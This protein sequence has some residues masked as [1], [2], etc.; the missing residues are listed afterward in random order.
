MFKTKKTTKITKKVFRN[1]KWKFGLMITDLRFQQILKW[2]FICIKNKKYYFYYFFRCLLPGFISCF[3]DSFHYYL[4]NC[5]LFPLFEILR[6]ASKGFCVL[7]RKT[8]RIQSKANLFT[9]TT[10][11]VFSFWDA[12]SFYYFSSH[13]KLLV[14]SVKN[15]C[16]ENHQK[17]E[18]TGKQKA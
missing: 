7:I 1:K 18:E 6:V 2:L 10:F 15:L 11:V 4:F 17:D 9:L 8:S 12:S 5:I 3:C 13:R 14:L 16:D